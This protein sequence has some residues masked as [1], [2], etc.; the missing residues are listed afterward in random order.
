MST[1]RK[2]T[3]E[4]EARLLAEIEAFSQEL[5]HLLGDSVSS[6]ADERR[7]ISGSS[8]RLLLEESL[9][10]VKQFLVESAHRKPA[11]ARDVGESAYALWLF[12]S[13]MAYFQG[14]SVLDTDFDALVEFFF[15]WYPRHAQAAS[16]ALTICL[17]NS[18]TEFFAWLAEEEALPS[19][20]FMEDFLPLG[21]MA[22]RLLRF[23]KQMDPESPFFEEQFNALFGLR[24]PDSSR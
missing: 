22:P 5:E 12:A 10:W 4:E 24:P 9:E 1:P 16:E 21:E 17:L 15:W 2:R 14:L 18:L 13:Y 23:Y 11:A 6:L 20:L 8:P 7:S 3:D 19:H